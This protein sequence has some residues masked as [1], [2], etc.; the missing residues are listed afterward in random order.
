[1]TNGSTRRL[2]VRLHLWAVE[3]LAMSKKVESGSLRAAA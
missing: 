1:M 2:T 3:P